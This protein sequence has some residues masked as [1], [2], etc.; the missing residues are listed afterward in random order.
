MEK[1]A[2]PLDVN[3][4]AELLK[5]VSST[6]GTKFINRYSDLFCGIALDAVK[7]VYI[8]ENGRKEI[9]IKRYVRVEKVCFST[10]IDS[11]LIRFLVAR[12]L[13]QS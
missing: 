13:N 1:L 7:T 2:V 6:L 5:I 8:E 11:N 12:L 10:L 9:D 3:N 4:R